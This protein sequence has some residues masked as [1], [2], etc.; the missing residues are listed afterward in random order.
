[1][2]TPSELL[3]RFRRLYSADIRDPESI[4]ERWTED[5]VIEQSPDMLDTAGRFEGHDGVRGV[6]GEIAESYSGVV[7]LPVEVDALGGDRYLVLLEVT[8]HGKGSGIG[9][10][11]QIGHVVTLRDGRIAR[12][13]VHLSWDEARQAAAREETAR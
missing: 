12:M 2:A 10:E 3:E 8:G 4:R 7:W 6:L 1:V 11:T 13:E 9:L 5:A